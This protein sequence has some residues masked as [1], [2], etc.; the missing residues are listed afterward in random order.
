MKKAIYSII[1]TLLLAGGSPLLAQELTTPEQY[2]Q[3]YETL[4]KN[5]GLSGVG[6]ETHIQ[7][8]EKAFPD[9]NAM[10][11]AKFIYYLEKSR[12]IQ[13][14]QMNQSTYLGQK[15]YL[16]L[17]DSLGRDVHYFQDYV[18]DDEVF[19]KCITAIDNAISKN[20][21]RLD[22][23][24]YK[25]TALSSYE[26]TDPDMTVAALRSIIDYNFTQKPHWTYDG[27]DKVDAEFFD[28]A[29]QEYCVAFFRNA[30]LNSYD[31]FRDISLKMLDYEPDNVLFLD[32]LGSYYFVAMSDNKT[33]LKYYTKVLK[34]KKDDNA[35]I[36]NCIIMARRDGDTKMEKK[37]LEMMAKY[38]ESETDRTSAAGRLQYL[39]K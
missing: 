5:L 19:G 35:A 32:N 27:V 11:E 20:Q 29:V 2:R 15:P 8:W 13:M 10:L 14:V 12:N 1:C 23:R 17:K 26:K 39:P 37:Y 6:I 31:A 33:A 22:Y 4:V 30:T 36:R 16:S 28:A 38:G 7:K 34:I 9:D 25:I 3:R 18:F 21:D 24:L